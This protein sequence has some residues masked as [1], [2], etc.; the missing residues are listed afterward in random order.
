[1][2]PQTLLSITLLGSAC[3]A[4]PVLAKTVVI[5]PYI[6]VDQSIYAPLKGGGEVLASTTLAAGVDASVTGSRTQAQLAYRVERNIGWKKGSP[7]NLTHSGL[8]RVNYNITPQSLSFEA[9]AIATRTR[10]DIRGNA[11][12]NNQANVENLS[13]LYSVYAGPSLHTVA[14]QLNVNAAYRVGYTKVDSTTSSP[15]VVG[16]PVLNTFDHSVTQQLS[17]SVGMKS[18]VL[19]FGW[20]ASGAWARDDASQLDQRLDQKHIRGDVVVP[21]TPTVAAVGGVGYEKITASQRDAVST[22]DP[23]TLLPVPTLVNGQYQT[24]PGSPRLPYYDFS[25][26]YW[27]AGVLWRPTNHTSLE[28]RVGRRFGSWSYTGSFSSALSETTAVRVGVYDEIDTFGSQLNNGLAALPTSFTAVQNPF[29][30]QYGGCVY[31]GQGGGA[32][33]CLSGA[34]QSTSSSVYR[35]RGVT[36]IITSRRGP[37][38]YG[39]AAGYARRSY[40]TPNTGPLATLNGVSDQSAFIQA[41]LSRKLTPTSEFD[42]NLYANW[43]KSGILGAPTVT[44]YGASGTYSRSFGNHLSGAASLGIFGADEV[45]IQDALSASALLGMRYSF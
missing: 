2:R 37:W 45:G 30:G 32:G 1:M 25:G 22:I 3:W 20:T 18:G 9:G 26:L 5:T 8:A 40:L 23:V 33:G 17:A 31:G 21:L 38:G 34:L 13:Q 36:G 10:T 35:A 27:D 19:P 44:S 14:G 39:V 29:S 41:Y 42:T 24:V 7:R 4:A 15:L 12:T 16:Q 6:E 11:L 28:A 43:F